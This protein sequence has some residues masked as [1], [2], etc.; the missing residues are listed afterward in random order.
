MVLGSRSLGK[1]IEVEIGADGFSVIATVQRGLGAS[2][3]P[4]QAHPCED[5]RVRVK[6]V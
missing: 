5:G 4:R 2:S 6:G 1:R 3:S